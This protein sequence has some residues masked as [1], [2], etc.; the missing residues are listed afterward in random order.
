MG[1]PQI[2]LIQI[3]MANFIGKKKQNGTL[4]AILDVEI[5]HFHYF[6]PLN[7]YKK[8]DQLRGKDCKIYFKM[9]IVA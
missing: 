1:I 3:F 2:F 7:R 4:H 6:K 9:S 5:L 8:A